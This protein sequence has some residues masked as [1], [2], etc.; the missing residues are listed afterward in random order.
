MH[1]YVGK[2]LRHHVA[3]TI[4]AYMQP[5][6]PSKPRLVHAR[7]REWLVERAPL[8]KFE[9]SVRHCGFPGRPSTVMGWRL[10]STKLQMVG[11]TH[12]FFYF[13]RR[14]EVRSV[15]RGFRGVFPPYGKFDQ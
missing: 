10:G 3:H 1:S 4:C 13:H 12:N 7:V 8:G 11:T 14:W 9:L 5:I 15:D 6:V 2:L